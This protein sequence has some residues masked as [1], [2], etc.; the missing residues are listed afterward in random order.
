MSVT[1]GVIGFGWMAHYHYQNIVPKDEGVRMVAA[2]DIDP[3]RLEFAK[4]LRLV[5]FESFDTFLSS[6]EFN[7]VLVAT[8]NDTHKEYCIAS[9]KAGKHVICEKPVT[10]NTKDLLEIIEVSKICGRVFTVHHNR[11]LDRDFCIAR[12]VIDQGVIGK[13]FFVESRVHGANGIPSDWR[14]VG[15]SGGGMVLDWG[16]HLIDQILQMTDSPV[17]R[18]F[19]QLKYVNYDIDDNFK[20]LLDFQNGLSA[21]LEVCTACFQPLPRWR[22]LGSEGTLSILNF[23]CEGSVVRGTVKEVDWS[24]EAIKH[25]AGST[26]T[27][28]PRPEDTIKT[29]PLPDVSTQWSDFYRNFRD[30]LDGQEELLVKAE[31][32]VRVMQITELCFESARKGIGLAC[33]I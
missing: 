31:E 21:Q 1:I 23:Q 3:A 24:L 25:A 17:V 32:I 8:P 22:V 14:R 27:M 6:K 33:S 2:Y 11:R 28:R 30:V 19:S 13:P 18:V 12:R 15:T 4:K 9:L 29:L 7:T 20:L 5:A 26:R 10:M 16:V